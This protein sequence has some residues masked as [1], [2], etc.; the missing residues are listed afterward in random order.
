MAE[1]LNKHSLQLQR[2]KHESEEL[3][4]AISEK[5]KMVEKDFIKIQEHEKIVN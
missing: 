3:K 4:S 2:Q 5:V 1:L